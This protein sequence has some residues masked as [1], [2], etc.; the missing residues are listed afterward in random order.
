MNL[1]LPQLYDFVDPSDSHAVL[2]EVRLI[3]RELGLAAHL[4]AIEKTHHDVTRLFAGGYPGF[5]AS[6]TY[7]HDLEHT[8]SVVLA[9]ARLMSG[10]VGDQE[11]CDP[12]LLLYGLFASYFHDVGLIQDSGDFQGTGAKYTV[13]HEE[14]SVDFMR[15]YLRDQ[16]FGEEALDTISRMIQCTVLAADAREIEFPCEVSRCV[17]M[18]V[19]T[20]DLMAQI[21]DRH[22]LEKLFLLYREFEEAKL[23]GYDCEF[24]LLRK[25][26][27]FYEFVVHP[28]IE[29]QFGSL[30][31]YFAEYFLK[32]FNVDADLYSEAISRNLEHLQM[33]LEECGDSLE[34]LASKLKRMDIAS[35]SK[36]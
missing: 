14:R 2:H 33:V 25:T 34:C 15:I 12:D 4:S 16:G 7:Y 19:G 29:D 18:I 30:T 36:R 35:L 8:L 20:A 32:R 23:P 24:D 1:A 21:A 28:R 13:G 5:R 6:N 27:S 3:A 11:G 10:W 9:T 17:G 26:A 31:P 22:Y